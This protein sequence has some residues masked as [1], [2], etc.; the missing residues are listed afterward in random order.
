MVEVVRQQLT[1]GL[2]ELHCLSFWVSV[3]LTNTAP[4]KEIPDRK[5]H[6]LL[7]GK[8]L[9]T[10]MADFADQIYNMSLLSL[11]HNTNYIRESSGLRMA[12]ILGFSVKI[13]HYNA[14]PDRKQRE[15]PH[16]WLQRKQSSTY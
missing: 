13:A 15:L 2:L 5:I 14:L 3:G 4:A 10:H 1:A 16:S 9:L 11:E 8:L 6:Y 7:G 12:D